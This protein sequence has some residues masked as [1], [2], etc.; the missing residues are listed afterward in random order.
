MR[1]CVCVCVRVCFKGNADCD[2]FETVGKSWRE[3]DKLSKLRELE[4]FFLSLVSGQVSK[5]IKQ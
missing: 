1:V 2:M 4:I 5:I 3:I